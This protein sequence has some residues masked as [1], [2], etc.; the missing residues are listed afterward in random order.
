MKKYCLAIVLVA[1]LALV[2]C[3][4][5]EHSW[6]SGVV[7]KP[8]TCTEKGEMTYTC[9]VCEVTRTEEIDATG[10]KWVEGEGKAATCVEDGVK[11]SVCEV[12]KARNEEPIPATGNHTWD[13][14]T[15]TTKPSCLEPGVKTFT[16]T[17][18]KETKPEVIDALDHEYVN[19]ECVHD[20]CNAKETSVARIGTNYFDS[21]TDA[22]KSLNDA[23]S[24]TAEIHV[25]KENVILG[26]VADAAPT[27]KYEITFIGEGSD[28]T[29]ID[30]RD[31]KQITGS[32]GS[33]QVGANYV[34]N[35]ELSMTFKNV[36]VLIGGTLHY[37]GF[38][39]CGDL[40]F[41]NCTI[42]GKGY[43][44]GSGNVK[45]IGCTFDSPNAADNVE[46][47]TNS[48]KD[49]Y[50]MALYAGNSFYFEDCT[51]N[52]EKGQFINAYR[53]DGIKTP[54]N[55]TIK[56]CRFISGNTGVSQHKYAAIYLKP[57]NIWNV[58]IENVTCNE[59][60][61]TGANSGSNLYEVKVPSKSDTTVTIDGAVVW[62]NGAKKEN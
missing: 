40:T 62:A 59:N 46:G 27:G 25:L 50:N 60:V 12:C 35:P 29:Q 15:V 7:T 28:K 5:H 34:N 38:V 8:A 11:V 33:A 42:K 9:L 56:N 21:L 30:I 58:T 51:F 19:G 36:S 52:S 4:E 24:K 55:V 1:L 37:Q 10:H 57:E 31:A 3:A 45:F 54:I 13:S 22:I 2:G 20:G 32:E 53:E 16:C 17:V 43:M 61:E 39:R 18:C 26:K 6:D 14:G 49:G 41:E 44:W 48:N 23:E 47:A